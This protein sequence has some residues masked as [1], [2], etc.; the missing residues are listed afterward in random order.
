MAKFTKITNGTV[1]S[2]VTPSPSAS[3]ITTRINNRNVG[4]PIYTFADPL[5]DMITPT[6]QFTL[7]DST[8]Y[9][10]AT[11]YNLGISF[12][13]N[14]SAVATPLYQLTQNF[15]DITNLSFDSPT[16][17]TELSA[18]GDYLIINSDDT[19]YGIP[20]YNYGAGFVNGTTIPNS[21]VQV[22]TIWNVGKPTLDVTKNSGSTYLNPK[23]EAYS[24][25]ILRIKGM[26]GFPTINIDVCDDV[27]AD[28]IDAALELF[29][30]YSGFKEEF[31]VFNTAIYK[32]GV[33][34]RMDQLFSVSPESFTTD[35]CNVSGAWDYDLKDYR[36]VVDVW[37]FQQGEATGVNTLFTL[38]QAMAQQTYFSYMLGSAGFDL[39]TWE[40]LKGWLDTRE[41]VLAQTPYIRFDPKT[42]LLK[43]LPEP[44]DGQNYYCVVGCC[45]EN[46]IKYL[47]AEP[48]VY[49]YVMALIKL[50]I[51]Y[52]RSKYGSQVLFGGGTLNWDQM[53]S[54]GQKEKEELEKQILTGYGFAD[55][56]PPKFFLW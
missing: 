45:V 41:K 51:A 15:D 13:V 56:E 53:M 19:N 4:L 11:A 21:A 9:D 16:L 18:R 39:I 43:I 3:Y 52:V 14:N 10:A 17:V 23:L 25:I 20:L 54:Q 38:E 8:I 44:M 26:L 29:T 27:I 31:L 35:S 30:K 46:A 50:N 55:A 7:Y 5:V 1:L 33:G 47:I 42:Q 40:V 24:D 34:V 36:R 12:F 22:K 2:G 32:R 48:W 49:M 6:P 37:S 28:F